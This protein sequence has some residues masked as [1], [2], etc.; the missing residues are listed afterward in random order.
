MIRINKRG[1]LIV[2]II[3]T[4]LFTGMSGAWAKQQYGLDAVVKVEDKKEISK[5]LIGGTPGSCGYIWDSERQGWY[6]PW[7]SESFIPASDKPEWVKYIPEKRR[8]ED[9]AER[10]AEREERSEE[11]KKKIVAHRAEME[12]K[13]EE[14]KEKYAEIQAEREAEREARK[15]EYKKEKTRRLGPIPADNFTVKK[16]EGRDRA[17]KR[18]RIKA[19]SASPGRNVPIQ[20]TSRDIFKGYKPKELQH[21]N[22]ILDSIKSR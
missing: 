2:L 14:L 9:Q 1:W 7:D 21:S 17:N 3:G 12:A 18:D 16:D 8:A 19:A 5:V 10:E 13:I 15:E 4:F 6:Q 20:K 11:L 22:S